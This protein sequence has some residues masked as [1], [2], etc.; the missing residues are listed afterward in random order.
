[1]KG[2]EISGT[3]E[4]AQALRQYGQKAERAVFEAV[5]KTAIDVNG[6]IKKR[7]Q[8]GPK[9]GKVYQKYNPRREHQASDGEKKE[10]PATDTGRLV[11]SIDFKMEGPLTATVSS[12]LAYAAYLEFGTQKIDPRPAWVPSVEAARPK[13]KQRLEEALR[14]VQP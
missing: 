12:L 1:V 6:D 8:R 5:L 2:I 10:A 14:K 13:F 11:N 3:E 4:V 7:I 9:T